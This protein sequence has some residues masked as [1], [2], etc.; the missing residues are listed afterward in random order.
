MTVWLFRRK[1]LFEGLY[2]PEDIGKMP[3]PKSGC[4]C[5]KATCKEL[6]RKEL[7]AGLVRPVSREGGKM[8]V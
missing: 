5:G 8:G 6:Q 3:T 7:F 2:T 1:G 4:F